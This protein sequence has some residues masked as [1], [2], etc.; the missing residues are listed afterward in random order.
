MA[1]QFFIRASG[2]VRGPFT[3]D[4][5][6]D[7]RNRSRLQ[8]F[9]EISSDRA[10]WSP[11]SSFSELFASAAVM[12]QPAGPVATE[13]WFL[14]GGNG[15]RQGPFTRPQLSG[16][17]Q[18]GTLHE[19]SLIW[20]KGRGDWQPA[21]QILPELFGP[22]SPFQ[23]G[24]ASPSGLGA[25]WKPA[26]IGVMLALI[27]ACVFAGCIAMFCLALLVSVLNAGPGRWSFIRVMAAMGVVTII[28]RLVIYAAQIVET[29]G[30]GFCV[31]APPR[32]GTRGFAIGTLVLALGCLLLDF[33]YFVS[34][35]A[36]GADPTDNGEFAIARA[37][38]LAIL[39]L[40]SFFALVTYRFLFLLFLRASAA[41]C[42]AAGLAQQLIYLMILYGVLVLLGFVIFL[43]ALV[44][45]SSGRREGPVVV[46]VLSVVFLI[47]G[48]AWLAWYIVA[49]FQCRGAM[50]RRGT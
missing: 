14:L 22:G 31:A 20:T 43:V 36:G 11:A 47:I 30:F 32:S 39:A 9:H 17:V 16:L 45:D 15:Q 50:A 29:I 6:L 48:I 35:L 24:G 42:R 25:A 4:Q 3:W 28:T 10:T 41:A 27:G 34:L 46:L 26:R 8:A 23:F 44:S 37:G 2:Q 5:I 12:Q 21:G 40:L 18:N 19:G 13:D 1:E 49:L 33:I 38:Y 7:L